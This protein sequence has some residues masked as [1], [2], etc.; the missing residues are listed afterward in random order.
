MIYHCNNQK[1]L[2]WRKLKN[3][4]FAIL[5]KLYL[6]VIKKNFQIKNQYLLSKDKKMNNKKQK[7]IR[8]LQKKNMNHLSKRDCKVL[9]IQNNQKPKQEMLIKLFPVIKKVI[10]YKT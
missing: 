6:L 5:I 9:K 7:K 3:K 10:W 4:R 1:K 2:K 8:A